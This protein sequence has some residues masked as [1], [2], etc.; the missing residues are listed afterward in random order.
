MATTKKRST[1]RTPGAKGSSTRSGPKASEQRSP[2]RL[3]RFLGSVLGA[4]G[5]AIAE[6]S[7]DAWGIALLLV[8]V[9]SGLAI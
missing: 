8:A 9:I 1:A 6:R 4:I 2:G 7:R 3:R 5:S